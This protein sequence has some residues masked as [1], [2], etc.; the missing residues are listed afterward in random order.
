MTLYLCQKGGVNQVK[1]DYRHNDKVLKLI[2]QCC[3]YFNSECVALD[4]KCVMESCKTSILCK[5]FIKYVLPADQTLYTEIQAYNKVAG[6]YVKRCKTC[7]GTFHSTSRTSQYCSKCK[8]KQGKAK[9]RKYN[10][11]RKAI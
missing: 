7:N 6:A 10:A 11:S 5:W 9:Y 8:V 3:N 1:M 2:P 4:C